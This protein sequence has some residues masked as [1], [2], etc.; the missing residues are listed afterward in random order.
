MQSKARRNQ[1]NLPHG[2]KTK[3]GYAKN[4]QFCPLCEWV[5]VPSGTGSPGLSRTKSG[6]P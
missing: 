6:E 5:N 4:G 2:T 1:L 3:T